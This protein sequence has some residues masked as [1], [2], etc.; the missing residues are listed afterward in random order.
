MN[1]DSSLARNTAAAAI[2]SGRPRRPTGW[3]GPHSA[4]ARSIDPNRSASRP[5]AVP[6]GESVLTRMPSFAWSRAMTFASWMSAP[7]VA[8]YAACPS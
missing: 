3:V 8:Q 5:V 2:S 6:P 7:F 1:E 4:S